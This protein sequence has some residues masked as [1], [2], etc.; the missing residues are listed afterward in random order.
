MV[1]EYLLSSAMERPLAPEEAETLPVESMLL[2]IGARPRREE[3]MNDPV[4]GANALALDASANKRIPRSM[5]HRCL[6]LP[7]PHDA[8]VLPSVNT[9]QI[10]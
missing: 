5:I 8:H 7:P 4:E 9:D 10:H 2:A 3:G 1:L 6:V